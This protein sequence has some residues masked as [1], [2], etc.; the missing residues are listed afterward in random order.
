[1][2]E[3]ADAICDFGGGC[4]GFRRGADRGLSGFTSGGSGAP[5]AA[6]WPDRF[7]MLCR[8]FRREMAFRSAFLSDIV[9]SK[10]PG[11]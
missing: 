11:S 8:S 7:G 1:M 6:G 3:I 5:F 2:V 4:T 10:V 9:E